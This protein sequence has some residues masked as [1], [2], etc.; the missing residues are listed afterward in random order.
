[1]RRDI[2]V[3][4]VALVMFAASGCEKS[5]NSTIITPKGEITLSAVINNDNT[6]TILGEKDSDKYPTLWC[7]GDAIAVINNGRL[8]K[9]V[10]D[11][12]DAGTT[13]GQFFLDEESLPAGCTVED[14]NPQMAIQAFYPYDGVVF[15]S[16]NQKVSYTV[17]ASQVYTDRSFGSGASPMSAY[18]E[19]GEG[20]IS[21]ENLFGALKLQLKGSQKVKSIAIQGKNNE[22]LSGSAT[23]VTYSN[24]TAPAITMTSDE[25]GA[26]SVIL[27]CSE[28]GIQLSTS[29][30]TEFIIALPPV[31]FSN[32]FSVTITDV[33]S[34][35][36]NLTAKV[37]NTV[38][39]S[40][41]L[42]MSELTLI[43]SLTLS[44][45]LL[46]MLPGTSYTLS[47]NVT[48]SDA[49]GQNIIWS[50]SNNA[51]AKVDENGHIIAVAD[52]DA[53]IT[54]TSALLG[55]SDECSVKVKST[56]YVANIK[57]IEGGKDYGYG[58]TIGDIV[59]A[60]VNCGYE[61][62]DVDYN[63]FPYGK[64]YQWGRKY[65]QGYDWNDA[66]SPS[67]GEL[68]EGPVSQS[69]G[70]SEENAN[71]FYLSLADEDNGDWCETQN[72]NM[73]RDAQGEKTSYDPCPDGWRVPT[74]DE[75]SV[76]IS[77]KSSWTSDSNGLKGYYFTGEYTYMTNIPRIFLPAAG[78]R[79]DTGHI[80]GRG[81]YGNY[82]ASDTDYYYSAYLFFAQNDI[83]MD[84][85]SR[86][87]GHS[88]RCVQE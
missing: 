3:F 58:I 59:W 27:E 32:G 48:S 63:G 50:S 1:M 74:A 20:V 41:V 62:K 2:I 51:V 71:K 22:K 9:F 15:D 85:Y 37:S 42:T 76:L 70:N 88:V 49:T 78:N 18:A 26:K 4:A 46:T 68:I 73:W 64:L 40:S 72:D 17:P 69:T 19:N 82:W 65:G 23:I 67:D 33:S 31:I 55:I 16:N 45:E 80:Y 7:E 43:S 12:E 47:T 11:P 30:A 66:T 39:K 8:F 21:F 14:F 52:G 38:V 28:S 83:R 81:Y 87:Y 34:Q 61:P 29:L 86:A 56:S 53:T 54:A 13:R 75:L 60:P 6:K 24:G 57:Y 77:N 5:E 79:E 25:N 44:R 84:N 35:T 36:Y 10:V